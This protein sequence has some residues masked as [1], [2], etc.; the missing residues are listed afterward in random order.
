M[1]GRLRLE[2]WIF[3]PDHTQ[4][5]LAA[6]RR[7]SGN[8]MLVSDTSRIRQ[9]QEP[10][11]GRPSKRPFPFARGPAARPSNRHRRRRRADRAVRV[12]IGSSPRL[13]T[14]GEHAACL[15]VPIYIFG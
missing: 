10:S 2:A 8:W 12:T 4:N 14:F 7:A 11:M 6:R 13:V 1:Q 15:L 5:V 3:I 9:E